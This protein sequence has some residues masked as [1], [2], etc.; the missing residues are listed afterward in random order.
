MIDTGPPWLIQIIPSDS[1][2][3]AQ[4]TGHLGK[5]GMCYTHKSCVLRRHCETEILNSRLILNQSYLPPLVFQRLSVGG[6]RARKTTDNSH[7][8]TC[9]VV[10]I[11][12]AVALVRHRLGWRRTE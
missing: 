2:G 6:R 1:S 11:V 5:R 9:T 8:V 4:Q 7:P 3:I 12:F 10:I